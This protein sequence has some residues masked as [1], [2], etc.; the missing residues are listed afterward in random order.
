MDPIENETGNANETVDESNEATCECDMCK[1]HGPIV[2]NLALILLTDQSHESQPS[3]LGPV[4]MIWLWTEIVTLFLFFVAAEVFALD[5]SRY[6]CSHEKPSFGRRETK[7]KPDRQ[8]K[9]RRCNKVMND[10]KY[11]DRIIFRVNQL[12]NQGV[13][14]AV[15]IAAS[16][17]VWNEK[18]E[19][20][21]F[22]LRPGRGR[23]TQPSLRVFATFSWVLD[24]KS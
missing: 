14:N 21:S 12:S 23:L 20:L 15:H 19:Y 4:Y 10:E 9:E 3:P 2:T 6:L 22:I 11:L 13:A 5:T 16:I 8:L 7:E 17:T 1:E 18:S 24:W